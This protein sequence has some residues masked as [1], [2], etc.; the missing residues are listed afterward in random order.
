MTSRYKQ[1]AIALAVC[2]CLFLLACN[3]EKEAGG[4]GRM[5][6]GQ[7]HNIAVKIVDSN[8]NCQQ[9]LD[10]GSFAAAP[11]SVSYGDSV[12]FAGPNA[13]TAFTVT[14]PGTACGS[15]FQTGTCTTT[16]NNSSPTGTTVANLTFPYASV[17]IGSPPVSCNNPGSLG[18]IMK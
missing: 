13:A 16:F 14:F 5:G 17:T 18:L 12:T 3:K 9:S 10:G 4:G 8:N 15:P 7:T 1:F 6:G 2:S 11:A